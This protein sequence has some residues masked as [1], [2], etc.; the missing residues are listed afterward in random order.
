[1][2]AETPAADDDSS[3]RQMKIVVVVAVVIVA[4]WRVCDV[5]ELNQLV[6]HPAQV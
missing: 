1:M 5:L 4:Y 6:F 2:A 3:V